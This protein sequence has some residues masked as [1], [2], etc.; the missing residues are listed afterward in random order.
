LA[1]SAINQKKSKINI[2][3]LRTKFTNNS[4][5]KEDNLYPYL[6]E[7][8]KHIRDGAI[9]DLVGAFTSNFKKQK[10]DPSFRFEMKYRSKKQEQSIVIE[11]N[12]G[13]YL[14]PEQRLFHMYPAFLEG[15]IKY[16]IRC[17]DRRKTLIPSI[18]YDCRLTLDTRGH[19]YLNIPCL[20]STS[21]NQT[22]RAKHVWG[23]LDPGVRTFQTIYSPEYGCAY[24][25]GTGD[26]S[27]IYRLCLALDGLI[28]LRDKKFSRRTDQKGKI[29]HQSIRRKIKNL[30]MKIKH[31]VDEVHWKTVHF[32]LTHF[33]NILIPSFNVQDMVLKKNR[34]ISCKTVR[35]MLG[36][37]HYKFRQRLMSS[38]KR[39]NQS[40]PVWTRRN[41]YVV[42]EEYTTQA[43]GYCLCLNKHVGSRKQY[44]CQKCQIKIDRDLNGARNIFIM[45]VRYEGERMVLKRRQPC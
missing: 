1:L 18:E 11:A 41:V 3:D 20:E 45:N 31:V 14:D 28:S 43:C 27:R 40:A 39:V 42:G 29:N 5:I 33:Q 15:S 13:A 38:A 37:S 2:N 12:S 44:C 10:L 36:W 19:Y 21:D 26:R 30:R 16:Y 4:K 23:A 9:N 25:I 8:P 24:K 32:L 35:Q 17:R 34:K 6:L 22:G 7:T